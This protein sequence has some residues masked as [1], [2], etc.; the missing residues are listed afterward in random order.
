M[1]FLTNEW[2]VGILAVVGAAYALARSIVVLTP[3]PND[4]AKLDKV[5]AILAA[6]GCGVVCDNC[7]LAVGLTGRSRVDYSRQG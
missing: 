7:C 1:D 3:T 2:V 4:D 6:I 5:G